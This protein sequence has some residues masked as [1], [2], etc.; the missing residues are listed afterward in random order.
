MVKLGNSL[1]LYGEEYY[2]EREFFLGF[3]VRNIF[4]KIQKNS[5]S[6]MSWWIDD[7]DEY[8]RGKKVFAIDKVK[9]IFRRKGYLH[10][11]GI[12]DLLFCQ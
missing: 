7:D 1:W 9:N 3:K 8:T 10:I 5:H 4:I 2:G 6:V 11:Y 12:L